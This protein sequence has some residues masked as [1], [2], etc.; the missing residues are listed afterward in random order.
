MEN[1]MSV[2]FEESRIGEV[3]LQNRLVR[4]ATSEGMA[5]V[6]GRCTAKLLGL[7]RRLAAGGAGLLISGHIFVREEGRAM[8]YQLGLHRDELVSGLKQLTD[9]VH[10]FGGR[11][12]AQL[13]HAGVYAN[14]L[15]KDMHVL[16]ASEGVAGINRSQRVCSP[17]DMEELI[18]GF[19]AA[20]ARALYAGFDGVQ[21]H[22]A[23]G[24]LLSQYLS[25]L[26]NRREDEY[27]GNVNNRSK[28]LVEVLR[29]VH[30]TVGPSYPVTVKLNCSDFA[31]GGLTLEDA[32]QVAVLLERESVDGIEVSGG[33]LTS[34]RMGPA[35]PG[36]DAPKKE[37]YFRREAHGI[38]EQ[39]GIPVLLVGGIRSYEVAEDLVKRDVC[40]FVSMSRPFIREPGI[41]K[42]WESGD[43]AMS[44]CDSDNRCFRPGLRGEGI[45]CVSLSR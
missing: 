1:P 5:D 11:I 25:T 24:Y 3:G 2:L 40:T 35:R 23:H 38:G 42:R 9:S 13:A 12:F 6:E 4:S 17:R 22:A 32:V 36:I 39:L 26:F 18:R 41:V 15:D 30:K 34:R 43:H 10:D 33:L 14:P 28:L 37:A 16:T 8:P 7:Y 29:A 45:Y 20:A 27:G 21:L 31:E 44:R 19:A